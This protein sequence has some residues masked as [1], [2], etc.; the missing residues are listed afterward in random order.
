MRILVVL[1]AIFLIVSLANTRPA[2]ASSMPETMFYQPVE[3]DK[4]ITPAQWQTIWQDSVKNGIKTVIVQWTSH[5]DNDF[6]G[7]DGWLATT[8]RQANKN[9]L[10]LIIG[11]HM[12]PDY[13]ARLSEL[14][15]AGTQPYLENQLGLSL[16]QANIVRTKWH[17]DAKGWY[18]PLE[19]DDWNFQQKA[20][21]DI[22]SQQLRDLAGH[23]DAPLHVSSFSGGK[24]TPDAYAKWLGSLRRNNIYV[25]AQNGTGTRTL[26]QIA[27]KAYLEALPCNIGIVL[28]AFKQ[29]SAPSRKFTAVPTTPDASDTKCHPVSVFELRYLP[30]GAILHTQ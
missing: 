15:T 9:G 3:T 19:L 14:D 21:R 25:W 6:G 10:T 1:I 17:I 8:L 20:R 7:A 5:G 30:W 18:V 24:L 29:T 23:L 2:Q 12:D 11:L 13:Y 22:I 4:N 27:R 16:H 28:E 26:P